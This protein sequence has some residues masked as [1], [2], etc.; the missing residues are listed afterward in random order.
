MRN[1]VLSTIAITL[2]LLLTSGTAMAQRY[3]VNPYA[4]GFFPGDW[5]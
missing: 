1:I 2:A 5:A 4:G 3:E